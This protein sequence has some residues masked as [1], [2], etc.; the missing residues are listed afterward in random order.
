MDRLVDPLVGGIH[1]G[2]VSDMSAAA[3]F[4]LLL[5]VAQRRAGFMRSLRQ[6]RSRRRLRPVL[7]HPASRRATGA[8]VPAFWALARRHRLAGRPVGRPPGRAGGGHPHR[9]PGRR[10]R[11]RREPGRTGY[12]RPPTGPVA[13][14]GV[15]LAVPAGLAADLLAP[16]DADAATLLRGIDYSSV[17]LV[18]LAYPEAAVPEDLVGTGLLV[19]HGTPAPTSPG[20]RRR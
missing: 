7:G 4:P 16:H 20:G 10:A 13:A 15:V 12:C 18:T 11:A 19:P 9:V 14:D 17:A 2:G 3:V 5:A 8:D 1:A 6:G